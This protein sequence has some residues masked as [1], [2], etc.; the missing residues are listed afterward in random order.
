MAM[1]RL[2]SLDALST[3]VALADA[4]TFAAAAEQMHL[5]QAAI[6]QQVKKLEEQLDQSLFKRAGRRM[7][8]TESGLL[9]VAHARKILAAQHEAMLALK[10]HNAD[11]V[12][13]LGV[14]QDYAE[15]M[16][17]ETLRRFSAHYPR[18][19][20]DV[21]VDKNQ[22]L[23]QEVKDS[24]LDIVLLL[25]DA[26]KL[27]V[28]PMLKP[29]VDWLAAADFAWAEGP[30]PLVLLDAPCIFRTRALDALQRDG[31]P[32]RIAY[33]TASL[34][35]ARAA[36]AAG[37]GVMA[38]IHTRRDATLGIVNLRHANRDIGKRLPRLTK[39]AT[40]VWR[41]ENL[42]MPGQELADILERGVMSD[43]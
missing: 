39:L 23:L 27:P 31:V 17:P 5:T 3:M 10:G 28:K 2:L 6:S 41:N 16:L 33:S 38:R 12:V 37:L 11:G 7:V 8:L 19:R 15:D 18:I 34:A 1:S 32:H 36:G 42:S 20:L 30:L 40:M 26:E 22:T 21:R 25:A 4:G 29:D 24:R 14:P 9:L 35:G 13:R 43:W